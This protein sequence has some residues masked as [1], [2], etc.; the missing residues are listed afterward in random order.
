MFYI[1]GL[2]RR[3]IYRWICHALIEDSLKTLKFTKDNYKKFLFSFFFPFFFLQATVM[4]TT[5][6]LFGE[7][8]ELLFC[9]NLGSL[10]A[11][12]CVCVCVCVYGYLKG[13]LFSP[14]NE[15]SH[16]LPK[17]SRKKNSK[18]PSV[19]LFVSKEKKVCMCIRM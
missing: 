17:L 13:T 14:P 15:R 10:H 5:N 8:Q 3:N 2:S 7:D 19:Y 9:Q 18:A 11:F 1:I 12:V 6:C 16:L 4:G